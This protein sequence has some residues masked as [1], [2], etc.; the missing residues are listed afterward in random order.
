[1]VSRNTCAVII[2]ISGFKSILPAAGINF[3]RKFNIGLVILFKMGAIGVYGLIQLNTA[4]ISTEY[5]KIAMLMLRMPRNAI[6][7]T[8]SH[9]LLP[10]K[11]N[12]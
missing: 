11:N 10:T 12:G 9:M 1:M 2:K 3:L 6:A 8:F 4:C 5:K 7:H